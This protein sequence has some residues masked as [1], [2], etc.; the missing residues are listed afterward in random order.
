MP[1]HDEEE[2]LSA[3]VHEV[4][5]GLRDR[6]ADFDVLVVENGS[7]DG[8]A[9]LAG[10]LAEELPEVHTISFPE[11][12]YGGALRTGVVTAVGELVVI[13]DVD[14]F[15]LE[16]LDRA[17]ARMAQDDRPAIV[18]GSKRAP[19]ARDTRPWLRRLVTSGFSTI[20]RFGFGLAVS[21]THGMK[22]LRRAPL[23]ELADRC[24]FG[25][26]L[27]DTEL[28][29]RAER[30]GLRAVEIP[31]AVEERRPSR[32]SITSRIPRTVAG[33]ARLRLALWRERL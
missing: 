16:F 19:G 31:V 11:A 2:F 5:S 9:A 7:T 26:D 27:F 24:R 32:S 25:T 33:L 29:L 13:F 17:L 30:A 23:A 1:A 14:Y 10:R 18:V 6:G 3:A 21:D 4:T 20:L 8:T 28:V 12:D 15:D 22:V